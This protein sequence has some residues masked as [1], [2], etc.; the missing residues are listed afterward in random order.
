MADIPFRDDDRVF[1]RENGPQDSG[2]VIAC[3]TEAVRVR[4]DSGGTM[5]WHRHEDVRPLNEQR[6][7][8]QRF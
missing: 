8:S 1:Y 6:T 5:S 7:L 3:T 4:W 2:S